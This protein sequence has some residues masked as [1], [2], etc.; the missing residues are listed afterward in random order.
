MK[1][2]LDEMRKY[3]QDDPSVFHGNYVMICLDKLYPPDQIETFRKSV[4]QA[5]ARG[6]EI[7]FILHLTCEELKFSHTCWI[8]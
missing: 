6:T 4:L 7:Y 5:G 3:L 8:L 1:V 2:S